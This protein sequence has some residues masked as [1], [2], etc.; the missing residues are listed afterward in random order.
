MKTHDLK[1]GMRQKSFLKPYHIFL[2]FL[3]EKSDALKGSKYS[4]EYFL[5]CRSKY[6]VQWN[7]S[8]RQYD[9]LLKQA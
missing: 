7:E 6:A 4:L 9:P 2:Q 3:L 8:L 5:E 1:I